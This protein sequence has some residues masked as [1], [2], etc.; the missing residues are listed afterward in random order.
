MIIC[1][2]YFLYFELIIEKWLSFFILIVIII[3]ELN[4]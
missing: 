1:L 2:S 3:L 4:A